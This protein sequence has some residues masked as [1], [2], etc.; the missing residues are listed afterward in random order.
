MRNFVSNSTVW[1]CCADFVAHF[2][3]YFIYPSTHWLVV[4]FQYLSHL[5]RPIWPDIMSLQ[6]INFP[7]AL[8]TTPIYFWP[9]EPCS[10]TIRPYDTHSTKQVTIT[11]LGVLFLEMLLLSWMCEIEHTPTTPLFF[12][13]HSAKKWHPFLFC[14]LCILTL[15]YIAGTADHWLVLFL[16][17]FF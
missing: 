17:I 10:M 13:L 14:L 11:S 15:I 3:V 6:F 8:I 12:F 9:L 1:L 4:Q 7:G 2:T 5:T 16:Y